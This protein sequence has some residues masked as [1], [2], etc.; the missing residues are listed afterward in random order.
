MVGLTVASSQVRHLIGVA[1]Y[2]MIEREGIG[3]YN[4]RIH[5]NSTYVSKVHNILHCA[6]AKGS[7]SVISLI[8]D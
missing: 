6:G 5:R 3:C 4:T 7:F 2:A 8:W 1:L